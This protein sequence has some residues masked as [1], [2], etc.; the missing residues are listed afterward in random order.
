MNISLV[1]KAAKY[2]SRKQFLSNK[3]SVEQPREI[4]LMSPVPFHDSL[5]PPQVALIMD[6][7]ALSLYMA[8]VKFQ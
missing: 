8:V 2:F 3:K 7:Y 6:S 1:I 5:L 4:R